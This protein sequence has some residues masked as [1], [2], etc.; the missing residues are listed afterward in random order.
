MVIDDNRSSKCDILLS[1]TQKEYDAYETAML[2]F[3]PNS[4][5]AKKALIR[6]R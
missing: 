2:F 6:G 3:T 4:K 1:A 5:T